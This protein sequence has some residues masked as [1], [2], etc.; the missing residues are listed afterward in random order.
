MKNDDRNFGREYS[1]NEFLE[2][3]E[4]HGGDATTPEI[5]SEVGCSGETTRRRMKELEEEGKVTS[6]KI[7]NSP[8]WQLRTS[9]DD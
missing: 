6:R 5:T 8:L 7:G 9:E 4:N 3:L 2:A 1:L